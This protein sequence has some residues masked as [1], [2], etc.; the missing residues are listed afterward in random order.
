MIH[1][2]NCSGRHRIELRSLFALGGKYKIIYNYNEIVRA[3]VL[4]LVR[5]VYSD[6][7]SNCTVGDETEVHVSKVVNYLQLHSP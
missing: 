6:S 7:L 5:S 4:L 2:T 3:I 1:E